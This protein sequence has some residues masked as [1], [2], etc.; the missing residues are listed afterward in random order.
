MNINEIAKMAGVSRATV[1]RYLNDGYVSDAKREAIR[2]VI[3]STGFVPSSQAQTLRTGKSKVVGVIIPKISSESVA[4]MVAGISEMLKKSGYQ[5]L[6]ANTENNEREEI[7]YL[8]VLEDN[9]VDG[10]ILI[11]T[12]FTPEHL[13]AMRSLSVPIVV[14]GQELEGY[15][16][17]YYDDYNVMRKITK[18]V[19]ERSTHPV[20]IG[21]LPKDKAAGEAR[22]RGFMD[23]IAEAKIDLPEGSLIVGDFSI[24]SGYSCA[25]TIM[26]TMPKTDAIICATDNIAVGVITCLRGM[27]K[28]VPEDVQV[29]GI[30]DSRLAHVMTPTLT[31]A[32]YYYRTSGAEAATLLLSMMTGERVVNRE[33]KMSFDIIEG[34]STFPRRD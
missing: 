13:K 30:G 16:S 14:L 33:V 23:A 25:S 19:L 4:R 7:E 32:H 5:M 34:K 20:Y 28:R 18:L 22:T 2:K 27:D 29:T 17:V 6:L 31:T 8:R 9:N 21:V 3:E 10:I 26:R 1:S 11:G 15:S 12:V 24:E